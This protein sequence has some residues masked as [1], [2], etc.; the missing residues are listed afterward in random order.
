M[1]DVTV[2]WVP[3]NEVGQ[4]S[5]SLDALGESL[6]RLEGDIE[7]EGQTQISIGRAA[8][9]INRGSFA[10]YRVEIRA[11][12]R[13]ATEGGVY[14]YGMLSS[15]MSHAQGGGEFQFAHDS[16]KTFNGTLSGA[17]AKGQTVL[18]VTPDPTVL[19]VVG[20]W[21]YLEHVTDQ[22]KFEKRKVAARDVT[23]ITVEDPITW[24]FPTASI[25]RHWEYFPKC[26]LVDGSYELRER[27]A[28]QGPNLWDLQFSFET[29]R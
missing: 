26:V 23:T 18:S 13:D 25:V 10:R 14:P 16:A 8:V 24:S 4:E 17:E 12:E 28:G 19:V 20:D 22:T 5:L 11:I 29:T 27:P 15:F 7:L 1:G 21:I 2:I 3:R 9:R 6:F